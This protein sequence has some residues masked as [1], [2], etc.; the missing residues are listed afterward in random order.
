MKI[1]NDANQEG[2]TILPSELQAGHVRFT[3][4]TYVGDLSKD[5]VIEGS[6][7]DVLRVLEAAQSKNFTTEITFN[8][9]PSVNV[10]E[11]V[12]SIKSALTNVATE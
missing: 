1:Q 4:T 3:Q 2:I 11:V 7:D 10:E 12:N 6:T 8:I 9:A 5:T